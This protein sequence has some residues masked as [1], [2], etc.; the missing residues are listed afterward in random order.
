MK[1]L[2]ANTLHQVT[3][4]GNEVHVVIDDR[5]IRRL[6]TAPRCASATAIPTALPTP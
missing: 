5:L 6:K 2:R 4:A 3:V 1:Q